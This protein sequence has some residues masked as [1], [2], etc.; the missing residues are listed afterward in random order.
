MTTVAPDLEISIEEIG[1]G[2]RVTEYQLMWWAFRRDPL[3]VLS[4]IILL[5]FILGAIFAPNLTPYPEQGRGD[6][7]LLEKFSPPNQGHLL[8]TDYLGRDV[9]T[10]I[11]YGGR[12]S[13]AIGFLV[14]IVAVC[15]GVPL[16][17]LQIFFWHFHHCCWQLLWRLHWE[18]VLLIR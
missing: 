11:L 18:Q 10:R 3:A 16:G 17:G 2:M 14:V 1:T 6:P 15:I 8:G 13:L 7:N 12:S 4:L 5:A 9:L